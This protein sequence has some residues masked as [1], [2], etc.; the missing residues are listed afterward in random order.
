[1]HNPVEFGQH[2]ESSSSI[3][4]QADGKIKLMMMSKGNKVQ[5]IHRD[6]AASLLNVREWTLANL[7]EMAQSEVAHSLHLD[8]VEHNRS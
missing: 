6:L 7:F 3:K 2:A 5:I 1:V 4:N 8:C